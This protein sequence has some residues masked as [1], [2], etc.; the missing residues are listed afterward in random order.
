MAPVRAASA[1]GTTQTGIARQTGRGQPEISRILR[2]HGTS[3]GDRVL[4]RHAA[5]L[6]RPVGLVPEPALHPLMEERVL[7]E[8]VPL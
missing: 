2:F 6:A 1:G 4:R 5:V 8:A 3:E 7:A